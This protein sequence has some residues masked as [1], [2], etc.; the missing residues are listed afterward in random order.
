M[1]QGIW[2]VNRKSGSK[3]CCSKLLE[4]CWKTSWALCKNYEFPSCS[5]HCGF[6]VICSLLDS[7]HVVTSELMGGLLSKMRPS[8]EA[9]FQWFLAPSCDPCRPVCSKWYA[10]SIKKWTA[11]SELKVFTERLQLDDFEPKSM[12]SDEFR[13]S[14]HQGSLCFFKGDHNNLPRLLKQ[15]SPNLTCQCWPWCTSRRCSAMNTE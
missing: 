15:K 10:K 7:G 6:L 12:N 2:G 3:K 11:K 1:V 14:C 8:W 5:N 13:T 4:K 9:W